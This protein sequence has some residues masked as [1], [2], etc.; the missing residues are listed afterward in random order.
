[1]STIRQVYH[2]AVNLF[3]RLCKWMHFGQYTAK[4]PVCQVHLFCQHQ[5]CNMIRTCFQAVMGL[6]CCFFDCCESASIRNDVRCRTPPSREAHG[7]RKQPHKGKS[8][9]SLPVAL[10]KKQ[11]FSDFE[12]MAQRSKNIFLEV[13]RKQTKS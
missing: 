2:A 7:K 4:M 13:H 1:M 10:H 12:L 9:L 3:I 8:E 6:D 5:P 11:V